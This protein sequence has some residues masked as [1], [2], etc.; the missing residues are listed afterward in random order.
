MPGFLWDEQVKKISSATSRT[1][2]Y[3]D[4]ASRG[5]QKE[6]GFRPFVSVVEILVDREDLRTWF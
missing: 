2:L 6:G 1:V 3:R 5:L 4:I